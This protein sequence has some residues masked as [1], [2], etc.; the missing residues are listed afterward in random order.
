MANIVLIA[1]GRSFCRVKREVEEP[2]AV[3]FRRECR[4]LCMARSRSAAAAKEAA[5][6]ACSVPRA[7]S[8]Q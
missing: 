5:H 3:K 6:G 4:D 7:L 8:A 1:A 2:A